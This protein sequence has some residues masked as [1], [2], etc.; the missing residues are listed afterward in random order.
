MVAILD[1]VPRNLTG[2]CQFW[3]LSH[4]PSYSELLFNDTL[5]SVLLSVIYDKTSLTNKVYKAQ[6]IQSQS[7]VRLN[8]DQYFGRDY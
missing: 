2:P 5:N 8:S 6:R 3:E 7:E 1:K 4:F